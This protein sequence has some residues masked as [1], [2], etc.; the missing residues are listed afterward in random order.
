MAAGYGLGVRQFQRGSP[1][2][3]CRRYLRGPDQ[4]DQYQAASSP[5]TKTP[6]VNSNKARVWMSTPTICVPTKGRPSGRGPTI[7]PGPGAKSRMGPDPAIRR[8]AKAME[9][10]LRPLRRAKPATMIR[11]P[12]RAAAATAMGGRQKEGRSR[13]GGAVTPRA[14]AHAP[15]KRRGSNALFPSTS[16]G[17]PPSA[18]ASSRSAVRS[19]AISLATGSGTPSRRH[20]RRHSSTNSLS[21]LPPL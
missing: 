5:R 21:A 16:S 10:L 8:V 4:G 15:A 3:P 2:P 6:T 1:L 9:L 18:A 14:A 13:L 11:T 7:L 20:S 17:E 12:R 19:A